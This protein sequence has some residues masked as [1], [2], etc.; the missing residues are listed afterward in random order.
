VSSPPPINL[1]YLNQVSDGDQ[2]FELELL[3]LFIEDA[4]Y[5][6]DAATEAIALQ[7][8]KALERE[9]HHLKGSSSNVGAQSMQ[10]IAYSIEQQSL[11]N[12]LEDVPT[13]IA[14]LKSCLEEVKVFV[15]ARF[16]LEI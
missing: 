6:L 15:S 11:K 16:N 2:D 4:Q 8:C 7:D 3:N 13:K 10:A 5:H 14:E 12:S 9:A 1:Q